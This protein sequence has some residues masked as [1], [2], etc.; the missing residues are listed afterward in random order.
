MSRSCCTFT[1]FV[2]LSIT[3]LAPTTSLA[4][5]HSPFPHPRQD[6]QHQPAGQEL[7]PGQNQGVRSGQLPQGLTLS[8]WA[9]IRA[10]ITAG[11]YCAYKHKNG[12]FIS[13]NPAHG[14][15]IHYAADG[16]T[17]LKPRNGDAQTDSQ[18]YYL[19]LKLSAAG[20]GELQSLD[21]P[22]Q[23]SVDDST[24]SYRWNDYLSEWWVNSSSGLEQ[25]FKLERRPP[26]S[27]SGEYLTL[28]MA[29][30]SDLEGSQNGNA[31]SFVNDTGTA[32]SYDKLK[33]W[34]ANGRELPARMQLHTGQLSL[35]IDDSNARY[36]LTIDPSIQQQA[37]LKAS[38]TASFDRFGASIAISG[39]T[40]VVGADWED[41]AATGING[42]QN[43]NSA[44]VAGAVY[45]FTRTGTT[46]TQQAYLKASNAESNDMFG[47]SVA[48]SGDTVVVGAIQ[49]RSN[50]TGV[51]GDQ[52][53]NSAGKAGAAYVFSRNGTTWS[54]QAYLKASN[55][56]ASDE[57]GRSVAVSGDTVVVGV[58]GER[59]NATGINGDQ[60]DNS[61]TWAGAAY[62]F[63]RNGT[64]WSQQA[65]IK[66]SNTDKQDQFGN[67]VAISG[68]TLVVGAP[69]ENSNATGING[70]QTDN[71][72]DDAGAVY[73]FTRNG[74]VWN[75]QAYLKASNTNKFDSF[76]K[77]VAI[78]GDTIVVGAWAES[79]K[80]TG[81]NGDQLDN[82][83]SSAGAAYVFTRN[84][85]TWS[86]QAYIKA[87]NTEKYDSFGVS[88]AVS[89]DILVVGASGED[90]SATG[91]NGDQI[92]NSASS[93]GAA[94]IFTRNG[95]VW[96][97]QAYLKASN[98]DAQDQ[99]G[100]P[101]ALSGETIAV[102]VKAEDSKATGINGDQ[103]DNSASVAGAAYVFDVASH[104][105]IGGTVS[106]L[107]GSG[108]VLQNNA[109]D[110]LTINANGGFTFTTA[111]N[112]GDTYSV[113]VLTQPTSPSQTCSVSNNSGT[114]AGADVTDITVTCTENVAFFT[115]TKEFTDGNN[116]MPVDV[117]ISCNTGLPI[118]ATHTITDGQG[119]TFTV[120][121]F[122]NSELNCTVT[123]QD[124]NGYTAT[125]QASG[126]EAIGSEGGCHFE[127]VV[128]DTQNFCRIV[129]DADPVDVTI[130][131][132]W[133]P[134]GTG[135]DLIDG[136]YTL[137][138]YCDARIKGGTRNCSTHRIFKGYC[139]VFEGDG[140]ETFVA[141]VIPQ[142]PSSSCW[143]SLHIF[144]DAVETVNKCG[145]LDISAGSGDSCII[146]NTVFFEGVPT[147]NRSGMAILVLLM[148]GITFVGFRR[149]A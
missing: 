142:Y 107:V 87:S 96:S 8:A 68:D 48:I 88:L 145:N 61:L 126:P 94:Y 78:S 3:V 140:S 33:A 147:L 22:Q 131:T 53:D 39:D 28:K 129:N 26:G 72:A 128:G 27:S 23:I 89:G 118:T 137:I 60:A 29:L 83:T 46:W 13:S 119:V 67:Q 9:D 141:Q 114:V 31:L 124:L 146:T 25:W 103:V 112:D 24:V 7:I 43:N 135:G 149:F 109:G 95:T 73:V 65:Y 127:A 35:V 132:Q 90:S 41:S 82:S 62:V 125:Y 97:Q 52:T 69:G 47:F 54:Q 51:N 17:T 102:G 1:V 55:T 139:K 14:W 138:L 2:L 30:R 121:S 81:I 148:L 5:T 143:V 18:A 136:S 93:A 36:P 111:L 50:A 80:A 44:S 16:T 75:Q 84:G 34:D 63:T 100:S 79:S 104:F 123:E 58:R 71:L 56:D 42:D 10:Q 45:V 86:Q 74:T 117:N 77:S 32:I 91:I 15:H 38:N 105:T 40:V 130:M 76:G 101:V 133:E 99:F 122:N 134:V 19:A 4:S 21:Q 20:F 113:S 98:T 85:S 59:S 6:F 144:D 108:L 66:A 92:N 64:T 116:P 110:D 12:G 70:D 120:T 106:G 37:Y 57:F 11:K 115:V 49:E